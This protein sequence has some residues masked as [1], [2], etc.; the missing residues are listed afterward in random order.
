MKAAEKSKSLAERII[1]DFGGITAMANALG[2][3]HASTVQ[4]WKER[5]VIPVR[6]QGFVLAKAREKGINLKPEDFFD[7]P[8]GAAE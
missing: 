3:K 1:R 5:G 4:G 7:L 8:A 6:Q 2:H